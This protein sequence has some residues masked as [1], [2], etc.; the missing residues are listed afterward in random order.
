MGFALAELAQKLVQ[1]SVV[2]DSSIVINGGTAQ[3]RQLQQGN[4]PRK[5]SDLPHVWLSARPLPW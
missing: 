1:G 5:P 2:G 4:Y 3:Y